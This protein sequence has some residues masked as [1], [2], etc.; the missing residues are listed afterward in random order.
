MVLTVPA[1]LSDPA[2]PRTSP[3]QAP[4]LWSRSPARGVEDRPP[5]PTFSC[6]LP[7]R[8]QAASSLFRATDTAASGTE[9]SGLEPRWRD[10]P[11]P[12]HASRAPSS[13]G[14]LG[15]ACL[16]GSR[17]QRLPAS[18]LHPGLHL[19]G[20]W[21]PARPLSW[22]SQ[23]PSSSSVP[24]AL[25]VFLSPLCGPSRLLFLVRR[26]LIISRKE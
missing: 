19:A 2:L 7:P 15:A 11:P 10:P 14:A 20:P 21:E 12:T 26:R 18:D 9:S 5:E 13:L 25:S 17:R 4:Q 8:L 3:G 23:A 16:G 1:K 24:P 22:E 6:V